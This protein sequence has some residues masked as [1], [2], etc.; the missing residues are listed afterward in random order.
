VVHHGGIGTVAQ[1]M[2]AGT[3]QLIQPICFDQMDNGA[4][5]QR[6]GVG[7]SL[8][9]SR[10]HPQQIAGAL[11]KLMTP[12]MRSRCRA[13]AARFEVGGAMD[14]AAQRIENLAARQSVVSQV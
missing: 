14:T 3:P 4:R 11:S 7:E 8:N 10:C 1:A 2:A 6:L 13:I 9:S 12:E 5:V